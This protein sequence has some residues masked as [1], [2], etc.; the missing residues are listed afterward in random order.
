MEV[1]E[2][3][4]MFGYEYKIIPDVPI[5]FSSPKIPKLGGEVNVTL[6][7]TFAKDEPLDNFISATG[8][9]ERA[10]FYVTGKLTANS[11]GYLS[12]KRPN[13][14]FTDFL[15]D[16]EYYGLLLASDLIVVLTTRDKT[17]QRGAYEAIY[18]GKPVVTSNWKVLRE[19]FPIGAVFVN[20]TTSG[21][22]NGINQALDSLE[23]LTQEAQ[24]LRKIKYEIWQN[25]MNEMKD[26]IIKSLSI[27]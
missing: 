24:E 17:M 21:I 4:K 16:D 19:N 13:L 15:P 14:I 8:N 6:V 11:S 1:G 2:E 18:F 9:L 3:L 10:N 26:L 5:E 25:N 12:N 7:N 23:K 27:S 20:N 22:M